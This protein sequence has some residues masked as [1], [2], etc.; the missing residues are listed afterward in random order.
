ML[1]ALGTVSFFMADEDKTIRVDIDKDFLAGL[2]DPP[3]PSPD[4]YLERLTRYRWHFT[5]IAKAKYDDGDYQR[6]VNVLVVRITESDLT[7]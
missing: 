4:G 2:G 5:Q 7:H 6:E 3:P 1:V